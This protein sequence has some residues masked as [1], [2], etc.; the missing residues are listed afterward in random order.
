MPSTL[1]QTLCELFHTRPHLAAELLQAARLLP[2]ASDVEGELLPGDLS[3]SAAPEYRA[4]VVVKLTGAAEMTVIIEAQLQPDP[5]KPFSWPVFVAVAQSQ[6][7]GKVALLVLT[8][9]EST[10]R[11]AARPLAV[12][13]TGTLRPVVIG[14]KSL[15]VVTEL[16]QAQ[17]NPEIAVL[18]ALAHGRRK[19]GAQVGRVAA[20]AAR[21]LDAERRRLYTDLILQHLTR[22]A[23]RG[24]ETLMIK[25]WQPESEFLRAIDA[26]QEAAIE[27]R[28]KEIGKEIGKELGVQEMLVGMLKRRFGPLPAEVTQRVE[29]AKLDELAVWS[30][31]LLEAKTLA[32]VF[33]SAPRVNGSVA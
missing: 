29:K 5:A 32:E 28:G 24:L 3:Q 27:A 26:R 15:P 7:R 11:W 31:R 8:L 16:G 9:D 17:E 30:D 25:D 4:D 14:P 22:A 12:G 1:H 21:S 6:R 20:E 2:T 13:I 23:R 10:A 18:S 33:Q 19:V